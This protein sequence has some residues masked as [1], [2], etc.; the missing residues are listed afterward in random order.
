MKRPTKIRVLT[1]ALTVCGGNAAAAFT[2]VEGMIGKKPLIWTFNPVKNGEPKGTPR[3]PHDIHTQRLMCEE[4]LER[5]A[6]KI[7]V[8]NS[9]P[10]SAPTGNGGTGEPTSEPTSGE[11]TGGPSPEER[12]D[13]LTTEHDMTISAIEA[14]EATLTETRET[15]SEIDEEIAEAINNYLNDKTPENRETWSTAEDKR[16]QAQQTE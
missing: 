10:S 5:L 4:D 1:E 7:G 15:M 16:A 9:E 2:Y 14:A 11:P 8:A 13:T 6:K 3:R 12:M